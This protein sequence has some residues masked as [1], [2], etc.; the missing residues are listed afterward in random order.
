MDDEFDGWE[1]WQAGVSTFADPVEAVSG[2][3]SV[4]FDNLAVSN[5]GVSMVQIFDVVPFQQYRIKVWF[6]AENLTAD[7]LGISVNGVGEDGRIDWDRRVS[8]Q[9]L[10]YPSPDGDG[11]ERNYK[12]YFINADDLTLDWTEVTVSFNSVDLTKVG[13][14][15]SVAG[16]RGNGGRIWWDDVRIDPSPTLNVIRRASLPLAIVGADGFAY[17]E[18]VD[19]DPISDP[20]LGTVIWDG[21]YDTHHAPPTITV[22]AGSSIGSGENVYFS[23]YHAM[24]AMYG[25]VACS[26]SDSGVYNLMDTVISEAE[27]AFTPDGYLL[28]YGEIR[29]GGWEPDQVTNYNSM[30]EVLAAHIAEV[31]N[32]VDT[33]TGNKPLH[34]WSDMFDPYHNAIE[35][36]YHVN[37]TL[38][39]SWLGLP[40]H[41]GV[42][43]WIGSV[44]EHHGPYKAAA[45]DSLQHFEAR[46]HEQII[47][48]YYD[49]NVI[50]NYRGWMTAAD[51]VSNVTGVMYTTWTNSPRGGTDHSDLEVFARTWWD[52]GRNQLVGG[53]RLYA[54]ESIETEDAACRLVF[55]TDGDL[56]AYANGEAYW[57]AGTQVAARGGWAEMQVDGNFV[58]YGAAGVA[59]WSS[60]TG[61]NPGARLVIENDCNVVVRAS[62]GTQ[63]W[64]TGRPLPLGGLT[65]GNVARAVHLTELR[66]RIDAARRQCGLANVSW[67]DPDIVS[68]V[69]P[70]KAVHI[71]QPRTA[72]DA[73]YLACGRMPPSWIDPEIIPGVTS[74]KA[75][76]FAELRDAVQGLN[77][78]PGNQAPETVGTIFPPRR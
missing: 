37:N 35:H 12:S 38:D 40:M 24:L 58:A 27:T 29:T 72:L 28:N 6:K 14:A 52:G 71:T 55:Q 69:T 25:Q 74:V 73:A 76:H 53:G 67:T 63:L 2:S 75:V 51:G 36:Y 39:G 26:M 47:A 70:I 62:D 66:T 4:R 56:V 42:V 10:S 65:T 34:I 41:V 54:G 59:Q 31:A 60:G 3:Y 20:K 19:F 48:A 18:G 77:G 21:N 16:G 43:N 17:T 64:A 1:T 33:L 61:G 15:L 11:I 44:P 57:S 49:S 7:W 13:V 8:S 23:G 46:G 45:R 50:D 68:G 5:G 30:G 78:T 9:W 22:P 32:R